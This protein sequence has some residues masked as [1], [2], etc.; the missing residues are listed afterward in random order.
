MYHDEVATF[1]KETW[2]E[3]GR[4]HVRAEGRMDLIREPASLERIVFPDPANC[5]R[6][7]KGSALEAARLRRVEAFQG[8]S[9]EVLFT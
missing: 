1:D 6:W 9:E 4:R 5:P 3:D 7:F 2:T 8:E